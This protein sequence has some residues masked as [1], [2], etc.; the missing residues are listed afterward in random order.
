MT[1]SSLPRTTPPISAIFSRTHRP[2]LVFNLCEAFA[3]STAFE[4][5][6]AALFELPGIPYT[7]CPALTLGLSLNK[8]VAKAILTANGIRTPD[9]VVVDQGQDLH[10]ARRS[11]HSP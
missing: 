7:G 6:V 1:R 10:A 9:Y 4:M 3:G 11:A 8:P 5:N 2:D